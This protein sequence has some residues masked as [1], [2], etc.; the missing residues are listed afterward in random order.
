MWQSEPWYFTVFWHVKICLALFSFCFL[1]FQNKKGL[2]E[3]RSQVE[4]SSGCII[5]PVLALSHFQGQLQIHVT[6]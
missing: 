2:E 3:R 4:I 5:H 1:T 6:G